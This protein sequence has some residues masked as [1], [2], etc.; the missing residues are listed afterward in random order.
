MFPYVVLRGSPTGSITLVSSLREIPTV[1]V[2][3]HPI[4]FGKY[5]RSS[6]RIKRNFWR[7][8]RGDITN[9]YQ[10]VNHK[11]HVLVIY[12]I[13]HLPL[14]FVSPTSQKIAILFAFFFV[15]HFLAGS[16]FECNLVA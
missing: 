12:I 1:V 16:V 11:S 2:L 10:V 15:R 7:H 13:C 9:I 3:H 8:C 5:Q 14:I 6:S 4:L